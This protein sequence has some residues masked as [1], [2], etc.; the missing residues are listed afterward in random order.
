MFP[1]LAA[2]VV[3][4][5]SCEGDAAG[6]A[7]LADGSDVFGAWHVGWVVLA[8]GE[9]PLAGGAGGVALDG[10]DGGHVAGALV[11]VEGAVEGDG[12]QAE[13]TGDVA[14]GGVGG[15]DGVHGGQHGGALGE[16]GRRG[17]ELQRGEVWDLDSALAWVGV[18]EGVDIAAVVFDE[19][20]DELGREI[21]G[22]GAIFNAALC[23]DADAGSV[24]VAWEVEP[25]LS[26]VVEGDLIEWLE[27]EGRGCFVGEHVVADEAEVVSE[28]GCGIILHRG[29]GDALGAADD[30]VF[31]QITDWHGV[32]DDFDMGEVGVVQGLAGV[33]MGGDGHCHLREPLVQLGQA[34]GEEQQVAEATGAEYQDAARVS[35]RVSV[36]AV[37]VVVS[38]F[39][40]LQ[41][42]SVAELGGEL[43]VAEVGL[44]EW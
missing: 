23:L 19:R 17:H 20:F 6:L 30:V 41:V 10:F 15:D 31:V 7:L 2:D 14:E 43:G 29:V 13:G 21:D 40:R 39:A 26:E 35:G 11:P 1:K 38:G 36:A 33:S 22:I 25:G 9:V 34:W 37:Q 28:V 16:R 18:A 12:G 24:G 3:G 5:D 42:A 8:F 4:F 27:A 44:V 32:V